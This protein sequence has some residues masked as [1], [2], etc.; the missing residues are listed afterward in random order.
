MESV[1]LITTVF[2]ELVVW[3]LAI[4]GF[5]SVAVTAVV[6]PNRQWFE[7]VVIFGLFFVV[8]TLIVGF[9]VQSVAGVPLIQ[10][11]AIEML[12]AGQFG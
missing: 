12:E 11:E 10:I 4:S 3:V 7:L 6:S 2:P 5:V 8:N 9:V 1:V